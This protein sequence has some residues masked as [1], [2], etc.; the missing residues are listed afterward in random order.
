MLSQHFMSGLTGASQVMGRKGKINIVFEGEGART[1]GDTIYLPSLPS[2]VELTREQIGILRGYADHEAGHI[3]HTNFNSFKSFVKKWEDNPTMLQLE[4]VL[5]DTRIENKVGNEYH[6]AK[7]NLRYLNESDI[8]NDATQ[9]FLKVPDGSQ[10]ISE[11]LINALL[12]QHMKDTDCNGAEEV[13]NKFKDGDRKHL[14]EWSKAAVEC[15]NTAAVNRLA[16]FIN[17]Q[18][19]N[20]PNLE[21]EPEEVPSDVTEAQEGDGQEGEDDFEGEGEESG[22]ESGEGEGE[23]E[24]EEAGGGVG[25][26]PIGDFKFKKR[27]M[28]EVTGDVLEQVKSDGTNTSIIPVTTAKDGVYTK[29]NQGSMEKYFERASRASY[30]KCVSKAA[31]DINVVKSKLT[32][33]LKAKENRGWDSGREMGR[34]DTRRLV[35]AYNGQPNVFR[36]REDVTDMNTAIHI[37]IDLSGS[38][39][40]DNRIYNAGQCAIA[41]ASALESTSIDYAISGF[42]AGL[43]GQKYPTKEQLKKRAAYRIESLDIF[44]FKNWDQSLFDAAPELGLIQHCALANNNDSESVRWAAEDLKK[45]DKRRK[46]LMVLSDG[47]PAYLV[48][49]GHFGLPVDALK[50]EVKAITKEGIETVGIGIQTPCVKDYYP[51]HCVVNNVSDLAGTALDQVFK[52]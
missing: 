30:D 43:N 44:R 28:K 10:S 18:L 22:K 7:S 48:E 1:N 38:M 49:G 23:G 33:Y 6:G 35:A 9:E 2:N 46:V 15:E 8:N 41:L 37:L 12:F 45:R 25:A 21:Q 24:G 27:E 50:E 19:K 14:E 34:L 3:R 4:N 32:R 5:E 20:D 52:L 51:N 13:L 16:E 47:Q 36:Q 29:H 39:C 17:E 40:H 42:T 31:A 26:G 11:N